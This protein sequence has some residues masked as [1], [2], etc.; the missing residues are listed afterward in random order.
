[1]CEQMEA[2]YG[3]TIIIIISS[4]SIDNVHTDRRSN[5]EGAPVLEIYVL[6]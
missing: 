4:L 3:Y 2:E 5:E 1:M 6:I